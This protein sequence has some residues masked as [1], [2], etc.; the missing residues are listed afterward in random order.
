MNDDSNHTAPEQN[1]RNRAKSDG[2]A[3]MAVL[4][5]TAVLVVVVVTRLV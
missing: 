1:P 2:L 5:I 3:A 4:V